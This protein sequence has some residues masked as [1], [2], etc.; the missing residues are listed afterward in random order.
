MQLC[1]ICADAFAKQPVVPPMQGDE[2]VIDHPS[3]IDL[4][5]QMFV[6]L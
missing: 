4:P 3:D 1:S 6:S 2:M 5:V